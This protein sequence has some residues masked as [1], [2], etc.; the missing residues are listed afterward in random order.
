MMQVFA[1]TPLLLT[2][3]FAT[4]LLGGIIKGVIGLGLPTI[5]VGLLSVVMP[6]AQAVALLIVPSLATNIWQTAG[7][8]FGTVVRR[9]WTM[10]F[11]IAIGTMATAGILTGG[12]SGIAALALGV[13]LIIYAVSGLT[14][15]R[16]VVPPRTEWWMSPAAGIATGLVT[17]ATG[18]FVI[19]SVPYLQALGFDKNELVQ[20]LGLSFLV[21]TVSLALALATGGALDLDLTGSSFAA[22]L[23]A[24]AGMAMG[25]WVRSR[26]S[27]TVFR[28]YFFIGLLLLGAHLA[29]RN[30]GMI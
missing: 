3:I 11:G 24:L 22:L 5:T 16:L 28:R 14:G 26:I 8:R 19:P 6:P 1:E 18:I 9:I 29:L 7:S 30:A 25:Q 23:P 2:F 17:G 12:S 4:F 27:A 20:A 10:M 15:F 21:A 13:T